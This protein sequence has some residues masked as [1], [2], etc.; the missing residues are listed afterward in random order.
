VR[1]E[2]RC[3]QSSAAV[4]KEGNSRTVFHEGAI[5]AATGTNREVLG[6]QPRGGGAADGGKEEKA[7]AEEEEATGEA[8]DVTMT[9]AEIVTTTATETEAGTLAT[10]D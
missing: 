3:R 2:D 5:H 4:Q 1:G 8:R 7:D 6:Y 10:N 9:E